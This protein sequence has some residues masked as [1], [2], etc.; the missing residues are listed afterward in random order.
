[1]PQDGLTLGRPDAPA[2][3]VEFIDVKCPFCKEFAIE[4]GPD[5]VRDL[6][7]SGRASLELRVL[8]K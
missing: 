6:V 5:L 7:R 2:T 8:A 4:D 1:M 3:V